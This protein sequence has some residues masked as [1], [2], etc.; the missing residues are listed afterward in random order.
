[1]FERRISGLQVGANL[2]PLQKAG[3][4][5]SEMDGVGSVMGNELIIERKSLERLTTNLISQILACRSLV[6]EWPR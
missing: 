4:R 3:F 1:M 2:V 5:T 6:E